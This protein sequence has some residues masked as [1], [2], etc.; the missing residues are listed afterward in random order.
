MWRTALGLTYGLVALLA[1]SAT[2]GE[3]K[4]IAAT[5]AKGTPATTRPLLAQAAPPASPFPAPPE[6][7][8]P[9]VEPTP[10]PPVPSGIESADS[11]PPEEPSGDAS[12]RMRQR[13]YGIEDGTSGG[14][15]SSAGGS[16]AGGNGRGA[17]GPGGGT[18]GTSGGVAGGRG[19]TGS[20]APAGG[21]TDQGGTE[22]SG[23]STGSGSGTGGGTS[24]GASGGTGG[25]TGNGT[26]GG[27]GGTAGPGGT[28]RT[29][30][31]SS[32]ALDDRE[33]RYKAALENTFLPELNR[34]LSPEQKVELVDAHNEW[35]SAVGVQPLV[36][37]DELAE[38][39]AGWAK[40]L[41]ENKK[42][43]MQH[44]TREGRK[45]TGEN[46][47]WASARNWTDGRREVQGV[48][49]RQVVDSWGNERK[50]YDHGKNRC[51]A[52]RKCGHYTQVVWESTREVGCA[53]RVCPDSTQVWVCNYRPA[54][55][56]VGR[57]PY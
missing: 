9:K 53:R 8:T 51:R 32:G 20:G 5:K 37:S 36:W 27:T 41:G 31:A 46:L 7:T 28:G 4:V 14:P 11:P 35:R 50:D 33:R 44:S 49:S 19:D 55:K 17:V 38:I 48:R 40:S 1:T 47:F 22:R 54:G 42:C 24:G 3:I 21:D 13:T 2:G 52:G 12:T 45:G 29:G 25:E 15:G 6:P 57:S 26:E 30:G 43:A 34:G 23:G 18:G 10:E 56:F 39:A 16:A